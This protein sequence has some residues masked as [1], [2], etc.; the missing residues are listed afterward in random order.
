M[1]RPKPASPTAELN[2]I[3]NIEGQVTTPVLNNPLGA[4]SVVTRDASNTVTH[5]L[6]RAQLNFWSPYLRSKITSSTPRT[7]HSQNLCISI[8]LPDI[9]PFAFQIFI[10]FMETR[11]L[12]DVYRYEQGQ[13]T[14][15]ASV[16]DWRNVPLLIK[17]WVLAHRFKGPTLVLRDQAML[18]IYDLYNPQH[19]K[20]ITPNP[21][22]VRYILTLVQTSRTTPT[23]TSSSNPTFYSRTNSG[24]HSESRMFSSFSNRNPP[25]PDLNAPLT[26]FFMAALA[27]PD[28]QCETTDTTEWRSIMSEYPEFG[29]ELRRKIEEDIWKRRDGVK[30]VE[31]YL[32]CL[33]EVEPGWYE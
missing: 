32:G 3:L 1:A 23:L 18:R 7:P 4:I 13:N 25:R 9:D 12:I 6:P 17:I 19:A 22:T 28:V 10:K 8:L 30:K 31:A 15:D 33:G 26:R 5:I 14:R 20:M 21:Q 27:F 11:K 24:S 16:V 29:D 2:Q